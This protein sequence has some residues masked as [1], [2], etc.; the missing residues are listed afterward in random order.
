M[1]ALSA[2]TP[3]A[4]L[5]G[6]CASATPDKATVAKR[7]AAIMRFIVFITSPR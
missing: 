2:I 4:A 1:P 6:A 7:P 5:A 3:P